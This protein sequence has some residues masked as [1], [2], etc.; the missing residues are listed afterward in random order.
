MA[1]LDLYSKNW[2]DLLFEGRNHNYG[3]YE[4]RANAGKRN[5]YAM[6][7]LLICLAI[8]GALPFIVDAVEGAIKSLG[9]DQAMEMQKLDEA[10]VEQE[11][12]EI[13]EEKQEQPKEDLTKDVVTEMAST[14]QFTVPEITDHVVAEKEIISQD[15]ANETNVKFGEFTFKGNDETSYNIKNEKTELGAEA[16]QGTGGTATNE[17]VKK[18]EEKQIFKENEVD[19]PASFPGGH[20]AFIAFLNK[21]LKYPPSALE[22]DVTGTVR[23]RFIV[24][25]DGSISSVSGSGADSRLVKEAVRVVK[26]VPRW[27]P[28]RKNGAPV[29]AHFS[30]PVE[31]DID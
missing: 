25:K 6:I 11:E 20:G 18:V 17:P 10:E 21:N 15:K 26:M 13:F 24:S 12:E 28:A 16:R 19:Q 22:E 8:I 5:G 7:G 4:M 30:V 9:N 29:D 2:C 14:Q 27:Q 1:K 31:F 23:V 3:A